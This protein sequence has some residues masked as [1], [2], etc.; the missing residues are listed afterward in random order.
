[1]LLLYSLTIIYTITGGLLV[2]GRT[3]QCKKTVCSQGCEY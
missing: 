2:K 3:E 1:M